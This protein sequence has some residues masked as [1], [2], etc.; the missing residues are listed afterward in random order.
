MRGPVAHHLGSEAGPAAGGAPGSTLLMY[1]KVYHTIRA[2]AVRRPRRR[3]QRQRQPPPS[4]S[5][6]GHQRQDLGVYTS[7][8]RSRLR[9]RPQ[10]EAWLVNPQRVVQ[11]RVST[12]ISNKCWEIIG[13]DL[14]TTQSRTCP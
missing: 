4:P 3:R 11:T 8:I 1:R 6:G 2:A 14:L 12:S 7:Y 10:V 9:C 5:E 13:V